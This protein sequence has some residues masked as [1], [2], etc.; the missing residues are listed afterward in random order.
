[1]RRV[2]IPKPGTT[3]QRALGIPTLRD[4]AAQTLVRLALEPEWE[5]R[6]EPNS[7][8]FR[9]G[10]SCHDAIQ[11]VFA[12]ICQKPKYVL[13]ADIAACFDRID[14]TALLAK[15]DTFPI[16]RRAIR[17]W[18]TAGILDGGQLFPS[19]AGTPQGGALSPLLANIALHGLETAVRAAFPGKHQG[20]SSWKPLVIRYADDVRH[21]TMHSI[22]VADRRGPE[23]LTSGP[24]AYLAAKAKG[25]RSMP[26]TRERAEDASARD[27][28]GPRDTVK[29]RL[30]EPESPVMQAYVPRPPR[31]MARLSLSGDE[32]V[33]AP[34]F[35][36][37]GGAE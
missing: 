27:S 23:E 29:A 8:G 1:V 5:A 16:L 14:Q 37:A 21:S 12:S 9:P 17:G 6:F 11:K 20:V 33:V 36:A 15:L 32:V 19:A 7:F 18:L 35:R 10:R 28:Q 4:R 13:D 31:R 24:T 34:T 30:L 25:D 2:W 3:Q 22:P 26:L